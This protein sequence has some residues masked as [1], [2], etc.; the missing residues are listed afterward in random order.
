MTSFRQIEAN[1]RNDLADHRCWKIALASQCPSPRANGKNRDHDAGGPRGLQSL[2]IVGDLGF[3]APTSSEISMRVEFSR[4]LGPEAHPLIRPY[5]Q[6]ES[7][8]F[9]NF[10][11]ETVLC[12]GL[13]SKN[14]GRPPAI[15]MRIV[16]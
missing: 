11:I 5:L 6:T 4:Q 16:R 3:D 1:R 15:F 10:S 13:F 7:R 8:D 9:G 2:R 12:V 14:G